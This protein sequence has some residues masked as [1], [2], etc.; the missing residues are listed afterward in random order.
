MG[1]RWRR[2]VREKR[3]GS[4][5]ARAAGQAQ[6]SV[7]AAPA[8]WTAR[9]DT[10]GCYKAE[11][12]VPVLLPLPLATVDVRWGIGFDASG[13]GLTCVGE[14]GSTPVGE[15]WGEGKIVARR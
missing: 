14:S 8:G 11:M 13:R 5:R 2:R 3:R 15:G 12:A 7:E 9:V 6:R 10:V 4:R 1:T